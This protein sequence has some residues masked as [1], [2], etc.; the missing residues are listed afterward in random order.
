[1]VLEKYA[2]TEGLLHTA[3]SEI[4]E[5]A[6]KQDLFCWEARNCV[7]ADGMSDRTAGSFVHCAWLA[8]HA[9]ARF[10]TMCRSTVTC[11]SLQPSI[12]GRPF[13]EQPPH[14]HKLQLTSSQFTVH[15]SPRQ[16]LTA[17]SAPR[18]HSAAASHPTSC[19]VLSAG[20]GEENQK[21]SEGR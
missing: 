16:M 5:V 14:W 12:K 2:R 17:A 20:G 11:Q 19:A 7:S 10:N 4:D 3:Y 6:S 21:L 13:L 8:D 15:R 9:G 1:M 18:W